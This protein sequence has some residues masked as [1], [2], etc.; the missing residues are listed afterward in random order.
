MM[1]KI[2]KLIGLFILILSFSCT[3]EALDNNFKRRRYAYGSGLN[4]MLI[5]T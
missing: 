5:F 2:I 4:T 1:K 3:D